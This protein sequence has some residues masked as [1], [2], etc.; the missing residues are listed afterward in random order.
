M[1]LKVYAHLLPC[2]FALQRV[3]VTD[4]RVLRGTISRNELKRTHGLMIVLLAGRWL[5]GLALFGIDLGGQ[6]ALLV[7][8]PKA[9]VKLGVVLLLSA[10]G[11]LINRWCLPRIVTGRRLALGERTALVGSHL[12]SVDLAAAGRCRARAG[13]G[14]RSRAGRQRALAAAGPPARAHQRAR[15]RYSQSCGINQPSRREPSWRHQ[16]ASGSVS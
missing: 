5:T 12:E 11:V 16:L 15:R 2:V 4:W 7:E 3:L 14:G 8:R 9:L 13:A 10:N 6:T 1:T